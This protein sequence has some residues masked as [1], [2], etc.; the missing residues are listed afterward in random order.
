MGPELRENIMEA[1][2]FVLLFAVVLSACAPVVTPTATPIPPAAA[3]TQDPKALGA[4]IDALMQED[5]EAGAV[6][7]PGRV[8]RNGQVILSQG[9]GFA[10]RFKKTPTT[11]QTKFR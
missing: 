10:D 5:C 1:T 9:Y 2:I 8:G 6:K 3:P 11:P 4:E 7:G